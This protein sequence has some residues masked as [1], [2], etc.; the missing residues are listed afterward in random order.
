[1]KRV[2]EMNAADS[3]QAKKD[4]IANAKAKRRQ[5]ELNQILLV[6]GVLIAV[7]ITV[8]WFVYE[9]WYFCQTNRC[10]K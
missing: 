8:G 10:G 3:E 2:A 5:E 4:A 7:F 9:A 6:T 1:M